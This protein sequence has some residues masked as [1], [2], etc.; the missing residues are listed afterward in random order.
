MSNDIIEAMKAVNQANAQ[1][2]QLKGKKYTEVSTRVEV[3]RQHFKSYSLES[4]LVLDDGQRV[5]VKAYIRREDGTVVATGY[6]EEIRGSSNVNHTSAIENC[7]TSAWGRALACLGLHG[8]QIASANELTA[9]KRKDTTIIENLEADIKSKRTLVALNQ[10]NQDNAV[11]ITR[12]Q[13]EDPDAFQRLYNV[14]LE[15]QEEIKNGGT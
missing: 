12:L 5:V 4:D 14:W 6:A 2:L 8:G 7:E 9:A 3:F 15:R 11:E 1:G 10:W 13:N